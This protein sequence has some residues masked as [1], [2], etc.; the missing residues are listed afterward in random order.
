MASS[1]SWLL[2]LVIL[3]MVCLV[4]VLWNQLWDIER[5]VAFLEDII[6][7]L[8]D[9]DEERDGG[10]EDDDGDGCE[11]TKSGLM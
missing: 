11:Y 5:R 10:G 9:W 3:G 2:A 1:F 6:D 7:D 8:L 4:T